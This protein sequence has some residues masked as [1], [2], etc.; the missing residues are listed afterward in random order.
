MER[1]IAEANHAHKKDFAAAS[2][3]EAQG[4]R[5]SVLCCPVPTRRRVLTRA[6]TLPV[7]VPTFLD[8]VELRR[9]HPADSPRCE[10][11]AWGEVD[12]Q[13][14][15]VER[16]DR[17]LVALADLADHIGKVLAQAPPLTDAQRD[18]LALLHCAAG[19]VP[20]E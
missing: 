17:R 2:S 6:S 3:G 5:R 11:T 15:A 19:A 20:H 18:R 16:V 10:S 7:G 8:A 12:R 13:P 1:R 9:G 14:P 4:H